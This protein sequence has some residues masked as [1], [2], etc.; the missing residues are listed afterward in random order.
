MNV[1]WLCFRG[2]INLRVCL[3]DC[4]FFFQILIVNGKNENINT[5]FFVMDY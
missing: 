2:K 5:I 1:W 3:A 4:N